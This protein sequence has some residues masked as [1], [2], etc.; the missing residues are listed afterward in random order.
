MVRF[1]MLVE[2]CNILLPTYLKS[3]DFTGLISLLAPLQV[4]DTFTGEEGSLQK[5][6]T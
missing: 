1:S 6:S 5:G 2:F 4:G 3:F